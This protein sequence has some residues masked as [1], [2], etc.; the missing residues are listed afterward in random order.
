MKRS[1][2]AETHLVN[3]ISLTKLLADI[4]NVP[5]KD[6][7]SNGLATRSIV[8]CLKKTV[9]VYGKDIK[10][11]NNE[12]LHVFILFIFIFA[13]NITRM[14]D[15]DFKENT[16]I[17][18]SI[19]FT[20]QPDFDRLFVMY[21]SFVGFYNN[22]RRNHYEPYL[23]VDTAIVNYITGPNA[24]QMLKVTSV[25]DLLVETLTNDYAENND[26]SKK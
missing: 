15:V 14:L 25:F 11:L 23:V 17:A 22:F 9:K 24:E 19:V 16:M 6:L 2:S 21:D 18:Y 3:T 7:T 20:G 4:D 26:H 13:N 8:C 10:S 1:I 5:P 12:E